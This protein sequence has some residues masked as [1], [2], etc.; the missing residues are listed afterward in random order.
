MRAFCFLILPTIY[1]EERII[2]MKKR[3][4]TGDRPTSQLHLGHFVG[5]LMNR[6]IS[7]DEYECFFI[8][9]DL[10]TLTTRPHKAHIAELGH[11]IRQ[12]V[13]DY[14]AVGIDPEK[15]TI[16]VQSAIPE[17]YELNT[18]MGMLASV[19]RLER[20][21]SLK[22]MAQAAN[23]KV[24]PY[25]LLGYPVL[26]AA[27]ILLPRANLV[28]VGTDN[29]A[30]VELARELARRFNMMYA[31]VFPIPEIQEVQ[32]LI[33]TDGQAKMSKS[34]HNAIYLADDSKTIQH[35]V[36]GMFTDPNRIAADTPGQ[37]DGNPIFIY[38]ETFN[39]NTEEVA[40]LKNRYREGK[41]GDVEVK[42]RLF[43]VLEDLLGP[44]REQRAR[45]ERNP[46]F[47][48]EILTQGTARMQR[49]AQETIGLVRDAMGISKYSYREVNRPNPYTKI[50]TT[51][52]QGLAF[53]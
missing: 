20:I 8:L 34:L 29:Q 24:I 47:I 48:D 39:P 35:K 4:L 53:V 43:Q 41:V 46:H 15:S 36:M 6:V 3:I 23:L 51:S 40:E 38:H 5:S 18:L 2:T 26:M 11:N 9:A 27:D 42:M 7:Q 50:H 1:T 28:P 13:L 12:T 32:T 21:P 44:I 52:T 45:F 37:V 16:F 10:H 31:E 22:E 30:N 17:I 25:G 49:E 14:L 19:P 33:G